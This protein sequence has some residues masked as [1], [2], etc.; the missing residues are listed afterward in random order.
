MTFLHGF[1][2][3]YGIDDPNHIAASPLVRLAAASDVAAGPKAAHPPRRKPAP[4]ARGPAAGPARF[5]ASPPQPELAERERRQ[6]IPF[7]VGQRE[8]LVRGRAHE[9]ADDAAESGGRELA[10]PEFLGLL[11]HP[12]G[13]QGSSRFSRLPAA[14]TD[15]GK[16]SRWRAQEGYAGAGLRRRSCY[17]KSP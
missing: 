8:M 15:S 12:P 4:T 9:E 17:A 14:R 10:A 2:V 1:P 16:R 3:P 6:E 13:R 11:V 7:E 5:A